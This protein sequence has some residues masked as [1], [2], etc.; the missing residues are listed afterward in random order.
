M[1]DGNA[2]KIV[3]ECVRLRAKMY[4]CLFNS[5]NQYRKL[6]FNHELYA[7]EVNKFSC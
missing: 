6:S 2:D 7:I 4:E 5:K 1:N 3:E